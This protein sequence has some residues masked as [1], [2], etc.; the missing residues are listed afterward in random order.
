MSHV[1]KVA[2]PP[3]ER[4][5][6][7]AALP[8]FG[9]HVAAVVGVIV[10]GWSWTGLALAIG[11]YVI[12]MFGVTAGYHRYFSHRTYKTSRPM[13]LVLALLAMSS[14]QK[15]VLWWASHHR[16]HHRYSDTP[17]DVHSMKLRGF[18]WSHVKW[19]LVSKHEGTDMDRVKDLAKYP[20]LRWLNRWFLV[21]PIALAV[22]LFALGGAW[23]LVWG[24]FV[25][26]TLL[27]HGTF[28]INSLSHA[29]GRRRYATTDESKNSWILAILVMGEGW[30]N[31]HHYYQR[32]VNQGFFWWEIDVT[33][34]L[35]RLLERFGLV[36]DLHTPP[37]HVL[38]PIAPASALA[39]PAAFAEAVTFAERGAL[40]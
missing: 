28:T 11:L 17:N 31:N 22:L 3:D 14:S 1:S 39:S 7:I 37:P 35:L 16:L 18:W 24:F 15:G 12:R 13:Q 20:E 33:Y 10:L 9:V 5:Q 8:F 27:W 25:S 34:Y 19:I 4:T 23:A 40:R 2:V 38:R 29:I 26:T 6:W 36:W 32:A 21:P 30:H